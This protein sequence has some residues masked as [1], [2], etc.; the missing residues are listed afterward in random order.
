M[1]VGTVRRNVLVYA[2]TSLEQI[3]PGAGY[4]VRL[5][6]V[7]ML[8]RAP[9]NPVFPMALLHD[10]SGSTVERLTHHPA[11]WEH[12]VRFRVHAIAHG[13]GEGG[14]EVA[15]ADIVDAIMR[16]MLID[17]PTL[18]G[19]VKQVHQAEPDDT[20]EGIGRPAGEAI[21]DFVARAVTE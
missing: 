16:R 2:K 1:N 11:T 18:G 10:T 6:K 13:Q 8:E 15:L 19:A 20:D 12:R 7:E 3:T 9:Q 4:P 14:R 17:D 21:L 5:N